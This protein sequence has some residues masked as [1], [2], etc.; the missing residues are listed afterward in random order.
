MSGRGRFYIGVLALALLGG[1]LGGFNLHW[2]RQ[3]QFPAYGY[4]FDAVAAT[5]FVVLF[6]YMR[7][8]KAATMDEFAV[9]KK[10]FAAQS[11]FMIG[12]V[13]FLL[14]GLW[15]VFFRDSYQ[16]FIAWT[17]TAD[18]AFTMGRAF[19]VAPFVIGLMLGQAGAWL[20]Y[21]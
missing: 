21:R 2:S 6:W 11:G 12:L 9:A 20:K 8:L 1:L 19:G 18:D 3:P 5:L 15:P 17:G 7:K 4:V 16:H 13:I 14:S 10:R